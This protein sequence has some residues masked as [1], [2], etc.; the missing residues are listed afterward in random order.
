MEVIADVRSQ[1]R[2][3]YAPQFDEVSLRNALRAK[4]IQYVP[5]GEELGGRPS[6]PGMYDKDG[7]VQYDR[8]AASEK[9]KHGLERLLTGSSGHRV[10]ILCTEE[11][12]T[13]CHRRLLIGPV[14]RGHGVEVEHLRGDGSI[15]S[16]ADVGADERLR[17]PERYQETLFD[18]EEDQWRSIRSVSGGI[19]RPSSSASSRPLE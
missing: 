4:G 16:E 19:P 11:D 5:M 12:P 17:Y 15:Q 1:P 13:N 7:H 14:L 8:V 2:S 10:A 3:T 18:H 9:F 6:G